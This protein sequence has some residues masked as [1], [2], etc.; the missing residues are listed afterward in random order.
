MDEIW[1]ILISLAVLLLG[2]PIGNFLAKI[3]KE[4]LKVGRGWFKLLMFIGIV[5]GVIS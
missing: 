4:E 1:K 2:I 5:G 3:T